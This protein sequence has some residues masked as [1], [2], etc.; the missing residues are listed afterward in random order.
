[1]DYY[2]QVIPIL[3]YDTPAGRDLAHPRGVTYG[4]V[5]RDYSVDPPTMFDPPSSMP[6]IPESEWDAR[7]DEDEKTQSSLEH[8]YLRSG[9]PAFIN[10]DQNGHGYSH[11]EDTEVLTEFGW[12]RWPDWNK[13]DLLATVDLTT[14]RMEFQA[15]TE[16][17]AYEYNDEMY[18]STN[19][20]LDFGVT[21]NH[22]MIVRKWD[23]RLRTL[24]PF[25]TEQR[26][27]SLG[28]YTGMMAA[29]SGFVGTDLGRLLIE[30]DREYDGDDL[31]ALLSLITSDG[32]VRRRD[33]DSGHVSFCCFSEKR[34][35]MVASLATRCGFREQPS[36][37]GVWHRYGAHALSAWIRANC[38]T[39]LDLGA[40]NKKIPDLVK[41]A[42]M[43]QI[44]HFLHFFGDKNHKK[45]G[46]QVFY[47]S[48]KRMIDDLQDLHLRI[49][50]RST[51]CTRGPR[52]AVMGDGKEI[53]SKDSHSLHISETDSLCIDRK[54]H[55]ETD[56]YKGLVYCATVPN[57][58]LVTRRNGSVLISGNCWAYSTGT[59]IML[60]RL[61]MNQPLVRINPHA[62]AAIIKRGADEGGWCGLSAKFAREHGYAI[63]GTGPG[64]WPLHSRDLR[65]DTPEL[66]AAMALHR[67]T[68]EWVDL[69]R[70]VYDV[71]LSKQQYATALMSRFPC[72]SDYNHWSH[73]VCALRWVR[74]ER[75]DWGEL[76]LNSWKDW[77]R[78]GL[79][80]M[81]GSKSV[82]NS[83]LALRS[84]P[85][86][87]K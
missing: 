1:M 2:K 76:I 87:E 79:A 71:E 11:T 85:G 9:G 29:P 24:S 66:R 67:V 74:I 13:K 8:L 32:Y 80:V 37:P 59:A 52:V 22:R 34:K 33:Q 61:S 3:D 51:I 53:R 39:G 31:I 25:Y 70:D 28:W 56:R 86:S 43:R 63:E 40:V 18:Y 42:S 82:P 4:A 65:Y 75:G 54:K 47:S 10:L 60:L 23:E 69:A 16:W 17:H 12:V 58:T 64:E 14:H 68:E 15:A 84:V 81:R 73:S 38:Y 6:L 41:C 57:G 35:P 36:R 55:I 30:G 78:F 48:S 50:K 77:G 20:R 46:Q 5:P 26:A 49:G 21:R 19:R 27:D 44:T 7:Y 62:T 45:D 72:P 83:M